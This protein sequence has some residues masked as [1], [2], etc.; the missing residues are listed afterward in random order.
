M[1]PSSYSG[2]LVAFSLLVA[3]LASYTALNMAG[4]VSST[5]GKASWVWLVGGSFA[6]GFGIWAM[7]FVGM[8]AFN[9]PITL[10]YDL[11]LTGLSLPCCWCVRPACRSDAC[12][13]GLY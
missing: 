12:A 7:H 10:S 6:M 13:W 2:L 3:V 9:L 1:L 8:L 5:L 4:R 11:P